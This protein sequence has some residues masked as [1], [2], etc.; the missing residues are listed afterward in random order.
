M[1]R[2]LVTAN[3]VP[4]WPILITFMMEELRSSETLVLTRATRRKIP[5]DDN[6]HLTVRGL[7][8]SKEIS[9]YDEKITIAQLMTDARRVP[10]QS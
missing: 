3:V 10:V 6:L 8:P 9:W 7:K 2:L 4:S 1:L 5:D